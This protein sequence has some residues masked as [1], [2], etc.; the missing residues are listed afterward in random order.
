M[1]GVLLKVKKTKTRQLLKRKMAF[2]KKTS[3]DFKSMQ[4]HKLI[5]LMLTL[6]SLNQ[7]HDRFLY[8]VYIFQSL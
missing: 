7:M 5:N 8:K 1:L 6:F 4:N 3:F 2:R